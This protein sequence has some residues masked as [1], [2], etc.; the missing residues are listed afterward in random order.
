MAETWNEA[1]KRLLG[2]CDHEGIECESVAVCRQG[3]E[4]GCASRKMDESYAEF[5]RESDY[6]D[7][8]TETQKL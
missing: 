8:G 6:G 7:P 5:V 1:E 4:C 2:N 3:C